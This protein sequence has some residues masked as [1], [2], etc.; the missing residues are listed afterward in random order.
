M[1]DF[2]QTCDICGRDRKSHFEPAR[3]VRGKPP[4]IRRVPMPH[5]DLANVRAGE[6]IFGSSRRQPSRHPGLSR[7]HRVEYLKRMFER[8]WLKRH[9]P[10]KGA[11]QHE[12]YAQQQRDSAR[13]NAGKDH[14]QRHAPRQQKET[15]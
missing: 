5:P 6:S 4:L 8:L 2:L 10:E 11:A 1:G 3:S 14:L 7:I 13:D 9:R 15:H 12:G